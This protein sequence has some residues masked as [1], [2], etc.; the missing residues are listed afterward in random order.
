M[1][2]RRA[3]VTS[4]VLCM[5]ACG[6]NGG[7]ATPTASPVATGTESSAPASSSGETTAASTETAETFGNVET[8][9]RG[10]AVAGNNGGEDAQL[11]YSEANRYSDGSCRGWNDP[12]SLVRT[13]GLQNG[14]PVRILNDDGNVI[15]SGQIASSH[16]F[17]AADGGENWTCV[18]AFT[19]KV[20]GPVPDSFLVKV[21]D[22]PP[23]RASSDPTDPGAFVASVDSDAN[24]DSIPDCVEPPKLKQQTDTTLTTE[25]P[26]DTTGVTET[27]SGGSTE[28]SEQPTPAVYPSVVKSY[29][30]DALRNLC[31]EG[32]KVSVKRDCRPRGIGSD[33]VIKVVSGDDVLLEDA[34]GPKDA[35][36]NLL[37]HAPVVVFVA[38]GR[39]C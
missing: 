22:L 7:S 26:A 23:W 31:E 3:A 14:A 33:Y 16:W 37:L 10:T 30:S 17:D 12:N 11:R 28:T 13:E 8:D 27:S 35:S 1:F 25:P 39:P 20:K 29:W 21:A 5:A 38:T 15:G 4:L 2:S 6:S 9:V 36:N 19:A 34:D 32:F 18:F 24:P